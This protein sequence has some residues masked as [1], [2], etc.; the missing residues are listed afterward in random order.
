MKEE[1]LRTMEK[2]GRVGSKELQ[3][4]KAVMASAILKRTLQY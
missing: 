2:S 3:F 4:T 1:K